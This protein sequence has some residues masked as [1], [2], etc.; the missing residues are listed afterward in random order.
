MERIK[1]TY[2][3]AAPNITLVAWMGILGF[4]LY[5]VIW[6]YVF[7]Q[8]YESELLRTIGAIMLIGFILLRAFSEKTKRILHTIT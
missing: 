4:P 6:K 3:Y 5:Y 7:P 1:R 2:E 8:P